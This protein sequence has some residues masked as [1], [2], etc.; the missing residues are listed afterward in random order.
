MKGVF[1]VLPATLHKKHFFL[2]A[3]LYATMPYTLFFKP[4]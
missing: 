4:D 2:A 1:I 3:K